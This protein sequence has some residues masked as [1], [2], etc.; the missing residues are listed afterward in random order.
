MQFFFFLLHLSVKF[1]SSKNPVSV[2]TSQFEFITCRVPNLSQYEI[3]GGQWRLPGVVFSAF[4]VQRAV[5]LSVKCCR[6]LIMSVL[7]LSFFNVAV[8]S[9]SRDSEG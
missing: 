5:F 9:L 4:R 6:S 7:G 1:C 8:D 2:L 3:R